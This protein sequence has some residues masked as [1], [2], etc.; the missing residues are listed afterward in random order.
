[1]NKRKTVSDETSASEILNELNEIQLSSG[2]FFI[3]RKAAHEIIRRIPVEDR[4]ALMVH[5]SDEPE[6]SR[7]IA[8]RVARRVVFR[9]ILLKPHRR[10]PEE[11]SFAF[12]LQGFGDEPERVCRLSMDKPSPVEARDAFTLFTQYGESIGEAEK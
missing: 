2:G 11:K 12:K 3:K 9:L 8:R 4:S 10:A 6:R 5:F 1:M 7:E